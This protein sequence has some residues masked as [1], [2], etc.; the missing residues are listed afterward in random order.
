MSRVADYELVDSLG[1]GNHGEYW[2]AKP[3][4][5]LQMDDESLVVVKVLTI[6]HTENDFTRMA[7]E[8]RVHAAVESPHL[9]PIIDA[10][11]QAGRLFYASPY[12]AG[13]SLA[14]SSGTVSLGVAV[15]AIADA[16]LAC[17]ALHDAGIAHRDIKPSKILLRDG[18]G[19]LS[20]LG[21]AQLLVPG[22]KATGHGPVGTSLF[23]APELVR[24]AT[25]SRSTDVWSFGATLHAVLAGKPIFEGVE[26]KD[27][28]T[29]LRTI[30]NSEPRVD[31]SSIP[32]AVLPVLNR[33]LAAAPEQRYP[34]TRAFAEALLESVRL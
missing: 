30:L 22:Q 23:L 32:P 20:D 34:T 26:G 7:N 24:G 9:V 13:G 2:L 17:H 12:F 15:R 21:L 28:L 33:C 31:E 4:Q 6:N 11:Q 25:A 8:L 14:D 16:A 3:P 1:S 19:H 10:G 29:V 27:V 18:R 5:R